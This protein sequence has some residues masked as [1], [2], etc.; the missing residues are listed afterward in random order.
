MTWRAPV[1]MAVPGDVSEEAARM[2]TP[3][4]Q[5]GDLWSR[6]TRTTDRALRSGALQPI[7]TEF[8]FVEHE[9]VRFLVRVVAGLAQKRESSSPPGPGA[10]AISQ[11]PFLPPDAELF[12]ADLSE[13]HLCVLNKFNV[14]E[15]HLLIVTRRFEHQETLL[16]LQDFEALW[17][18]MADYDALGFYNAG[19][20]AGAS[21]PHKHLQLVPLPLAAQ[22]PPTPIDPLLSAAPGLPW[23]HALVRLNATEKRAPAD[24]AG[25]SLRLYRRMLS[26][27]E[28]WHEDRDGEDFR[29]APYNL[30]VTRSWMMLVPRAAEL[31]GPISINALG[32][33]GALLARNEQELALLEE[34]G[35]MAALRAVAYAPSAGAPPSSPG[36]NDCSTS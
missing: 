36:P 34:R 29:P 5:R 2:T 17:T 25:H 20:I 31:F 21:Q 3:Q 13:T 19:T 27:V 28:L 1:I 11:N 32:F 35:P 10:P 9:G 22:G 23:R 15:H 8:V 24:L 30:L 18:C 12:V 26:K 16:T 6:V 33:A 14:V 4:T 7:P